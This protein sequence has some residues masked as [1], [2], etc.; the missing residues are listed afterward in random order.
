[1][2]FGPPCYHVSHTGE[3][4]ERRI[5]LSVSLEQQS[6]FGARLRQLREVAGLTQEE[7]ARRA[8]LTPNAIS[9]LELGRRRHPYPHTVRSLADALGLSEDEHAALVSAVP[10]RSAPTATLAVVLPAP[11]T[12]LLGRERELG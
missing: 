2:S 10:R 4:P 12:P 8:G 7:L 9:D 3:V 6:S 11:P 5:G 1:M